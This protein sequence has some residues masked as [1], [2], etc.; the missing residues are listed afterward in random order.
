MPPKPIG[1]EIRTTIT[2][3]YGADGRATTS[4]DVDDPV[5][6]LP[7]DDTLP[8]EKP[9]GDY[10]PKVA[11]DAGLTTNKFW[12]SFS[13]PSRIDL[14]GQPRKDRTQFTVARPGNIF[15]HA[16]PPA[17]RFSFADGVLTQS[18]GISG[19]NMSLLTTWPT[20]GGSFEGFVL[21]GLEEKGWAVE[22]RMMHADEGAP[23]QIAAFWSMCVR[24]IYG[25]G[26]Q[27]TDF[28][29]P[30]FY[31]A[32]PDGRGGTYPLFASHRHFRDAG[33]NMDKRMNPPRKRDSRNNG[34]GNDPHDPTKW[35]TVTHM[36]RPVGQND[37]RLEWFLNGQLKATSVVPWQAMCR[38]GKYPLIIG[39]KPSM[40]IDYVGAWA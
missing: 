12:C 20:G 23:H 2:T 24:H 37:V 32:W 38:A 40:K 27:A 5:D 28:W 22:A 4:V 15:N 18:Q 26:R 11:R 21:N 9:T 6:I 8:P 31:E 30:D 7:V 14:V 35:F 1:H 34:L 29:E 39:G 13:D 36:A 19:Y 10:V 16:Q 25:W 17:S 3:I 33:G